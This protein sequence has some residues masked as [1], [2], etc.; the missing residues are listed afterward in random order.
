MTSAMSLKIKICG[1]TSLTDALAAVEAGA[2][3]LGFM[4]Y[5]DSPR[6]V[7]PTTAARIIRSLPPFVARVGVF[8]NASEQVV[9]GVCDVC[10]LDTVQF[11]GEETPEFCRRFAPLK[12]I[13]AF[14]IK[15]GG[16]LR[17]LDA[18]DTDAWLLD[19]FVPG[20]QGG[21]GATFNWSLAREAKDAGYPII[22]AG[23]LSAENVA[24]A[25]HEVWPYGVDVSSGVESAPG[26]KDAKMIREF[27]DVVRGIERERY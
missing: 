17:P 14:R 24:Q 4:F 12:V 13:K 5:Q 19:A 2:D 1:L 6:F 23:G 22:L 26:R 20:L 9:R 3:A 11:H 15:N 18:Y 16:S 25:V 7:A 27:I 21:T 8:V 10:G